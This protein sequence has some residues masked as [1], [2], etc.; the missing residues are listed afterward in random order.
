M[1]VGERGCAHLETII[2]TRRTCQRRCPVARRADVVDNHSGGHEA[3]VETMRTADPEDRTELPHHD[4][5]KRGEKPETPN[6]VQNS[7]SPAIIAEVHD[8]SDQKNL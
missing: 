6:N 5:S 8:P 2:T 7:L 3:T 4:H 1:R